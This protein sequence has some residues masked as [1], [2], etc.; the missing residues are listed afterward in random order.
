MKRLV[1]DTGPIF[2]LHE[3]RALHL[4]PLMGEVFLPPAGCFRITFACSVVAASVGKDSATSSGKA[5]A[6]S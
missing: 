2:H 5:A 1:T 6:R 3:A 4:F